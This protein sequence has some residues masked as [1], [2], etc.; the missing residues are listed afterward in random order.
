MYVDTS[1]LGA[2]LLW[3][4]ETSEL[5]DW[6]DHT[7]ADL[8]SSDLLET[9]LRRIAVRE[10]LEQSAVSDLVDG[11]ALAAFDRATFR[12]AGLL[13]IPNLRTVDALH[14]EAALRLD[15]DAVLTY[16]HRLAEAARALG[17]DV[18]APGRAL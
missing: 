10:G 5:I 8:V 4:P 13:P 14:L 2:L 15:V 1:A 7:P 9:E 12:A 17:L 6:L 11:V 18:L 3:Q 16:D